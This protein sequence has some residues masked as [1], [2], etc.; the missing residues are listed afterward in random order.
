MELVPFV[1]DCLRGGDVV[2]DVWNRLG[3]ECPLDTFARENEGLSLE[4]L[5]LL[6]YQRKKG[7]GI[8]TGRRDA[9]ALN[10]PLIKV[11]EKVGTQK[12][13]FSSEF[14]E[15]TCQR[16]VDDLDWIENRL[17][18]KLADQAPRTSRPISTES[19]LIEVALEQIQI[20][21]ELTVREALNVSKKHPHQVAHH[22]LDCLRNV[23]ETGVD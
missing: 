19:E 6:F 11:L 15:N 10:A 1:K 5:A 17:G 21:S 7:G 8:R 3:I 4:A 14:L 2:S 9:H 23:C 16:N 20:L 13:S 18:R 12:L 22:L